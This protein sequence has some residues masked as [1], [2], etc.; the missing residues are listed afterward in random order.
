ME[1]TLAGGRATA[2]P[3]AT[4]GMGGPQVALLAALWLL[5]AALARPLHLPDEG[6]YAGIAWEMLHSHHWLIPRLDNLPYF[7]KPPLFYWL[8][9]AAMALF[10]T[11]EFAARLPS[12]LGAT[13]AAASLYGLARRWAGA[14]TARW[15]AIAICAH[16]LLFLGSQFANMDMLVAGFITLSIAS[17]AHAALTTWDAPADAP[18]RYAP[19]AI[20]YAAAALGVL[21]KGLIGI[22]LPVLVIGAWLIVQRRWR[23]LRGMV[24][25]PGLC[26]FALIA[27]PWF[28][29]VQMR[30]PE[31]AHYF[32]VVQHFRRFAAGGFNNVQPLWFYPAELALFGAPW[33]A[34]WLVALRDARRARRDAA[35]PARDGARPPLES[36]MS[37]W[38]VAVLVFFSLPQSKLIGYILPAVGPFAYL[39]G[40]AIAARVEA[41]GRAAQRTG[42]LANASLAISAIA[43]VA[44]VAGFAY[45]DPKVARPIG[46]YLGRHHEPG[47]PVLMLGAYQFDLGFYSG[48]RPPFLVVDDWKDPDLALHDDIRREVHEAGL[49]DARGAAHVFV[50]TD[51]L[52]RSLCNLSSSASVA[53]VVAPADAARRHPFL[54][55]APPVETARRTA[56]WRIDLGSAALRENL[57]CV[58]PR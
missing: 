40:A 9:A 34:W 8:S 30:F 36:L 42:R 50:D 15:V 4:G 1:T 27:L 46:V 7:D 56:L 26:I 2:R 21:S 32:F 35:S 28:V 45:A 13:L 44:V 41:G 22:V 17:F 24:W 18:R 49:F 16:P 31:Y 53:W 5:T 43:I 57:G 20:A 19:L 48:V 51:A 47:E 23:V 10:G 11:N 3:F 12:L 58:A 33:L 6:R 14:G 54:G 52:E 29:A 25:L 39:A 38:L 37:T 55:I